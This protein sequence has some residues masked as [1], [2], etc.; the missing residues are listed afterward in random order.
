[1]KNRNANIH[2]TKNIKGYTLKDLWDFVICSEY[3]KSDLHDNQ[4]IK[5]MVSMPNP[6]GALILWEEAENYFYF[7]KGA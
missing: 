7:K 2:H 3:A 5:I 1:M 4:I 6:T